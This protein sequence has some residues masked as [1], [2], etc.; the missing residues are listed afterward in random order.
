MAL[1]DRTDDIEKGAMEENEFKESDKELAI[2]SSEGNS[3]ANG[4]SEGKE[5]SDQD[6]VFIQDTGFTVKVVA[7]NLEP[8]DIQV[9]MYILY[10]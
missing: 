8:F 1:A 6:V 9:L 3:A 7:P 4:E 10:I 5:K 2:V